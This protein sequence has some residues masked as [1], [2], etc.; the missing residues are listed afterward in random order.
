MLFNIKKI[1]FSLPFGKLKFIVTI[2]QVEAVR[3]FA[4]NLV[5]MFTVIS[6]HDACGKLPRQISK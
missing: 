6:Q 5:T 1:N 2:Y 3:D 4:I